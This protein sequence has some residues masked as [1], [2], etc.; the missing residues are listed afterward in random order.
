MDEERYSRHLILPEIGHKGQQKLLSSGVLVIGAG[1]LGC[2]ILQ[3]LAAGGVGQIGIVDFDKVEK[4]NLMRQVLF[5]TKDIGQNKAQAAQK[6]L[7]ALN[8]DIKIS[9]FP[10]QLTSQNAIDLFQA[11]DLIIDGTDNF[12]TRYLI[13]DGCVL[14]NKPM[15]SGS[16]YKF[17]GQVGVFNYKNGP[18]YRCLYPTPPDGTLNLSCSELGVLGVLPGIIGSLMTN[19]VFKILLD[20][21]HVLNHKIMHYSALS[22]QIQYIGVK[23]QVNAI[24]KLKNNLKNFESTDYFCKSDFNQA[25]VEYVSLNLAEE[26]LAKQNATFIDV[27]EGENNVQV[28]DLKEAYKKQVVHIPFRILKQEMH[29]FEKDKTLL[30]Y[31]TSNLISQAIYRSFKKLGFNQ[32]FVLKVE[33]K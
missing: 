25:Q 14:T 6:K 30:I 9:S 28:V 10:F 23:R 2:P 7:L 8:P 24:E 3:Y 26:L 27:S 22:G 32:V 20:F 19:E 13:N 11:Y 1:G 15:V 33:D 21:E 17:E 29:T 16:L 18:T 12:S 31:A 5:E 4:S